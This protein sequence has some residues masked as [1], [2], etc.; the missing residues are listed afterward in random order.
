MFLNSLINHIADDYD[1]FRFLKIIAKLGV[2]K[3]KR[4]ISANTKCQTNYLVNL[5]NLNANI[6][7]DLIAHYL[8][9]SSPLFH[10]FVLNNLNKLD[11]SSVGSFSTDD[12]VKLA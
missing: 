7:T 3:L 5:D 2:S 1:Y 12:F 10:R 4:I 6:C 8:I 9:E 11:Y